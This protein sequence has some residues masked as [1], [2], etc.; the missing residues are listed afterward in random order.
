MFCKV[1]PA[2]KNSELGTPSI[3]KGFWTRRFVESRK[4]YSHSTNPIIWGCNFYAFTGI[5][6]ANLLIFHLLFLAANFLSIKIVSQ[7]PGKCNQVL[8]NCLLKKVSN[9]RAIVV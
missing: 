2:K 6:F 7:R 4:T 3:S 8:L 5:A 1:N 9:K